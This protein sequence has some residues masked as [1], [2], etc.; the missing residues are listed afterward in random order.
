MIMTRKRKNENEDWV[1]S[2]RDS[3]ER[4]G[5]N[6]PFSQATYSHC[7]DEPGGRDAYYDG[8]IDGCI[9]VEGNSRDLC[10]SATD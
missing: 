1:D 8:F 10:E 2:C 5:K 3:G 9:S 6:G 4:A 7:G